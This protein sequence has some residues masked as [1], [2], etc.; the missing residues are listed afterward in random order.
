MIQSPS[1][2]VRL[3]WSGRASF[4]TTWGRHDES[5][6][7]AQ[8]AIFA[9]SRTAALLVRQAGSE[10]FDSRV[11]STSLT[12]CAESWPIIFLPAMSAA[13]RTEDLPVGRASRSEWRL[14]FERS[15]SEGELCLVSSDE[16]STE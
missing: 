5:C 3:R 7:G 13:S 15:A 9:R 16:S 8:Y 4:G 2:C 1:T 14:A 6:F 11:G 12:P 10:I